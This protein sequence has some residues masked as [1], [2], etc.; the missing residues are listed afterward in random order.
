[1]VLTRGEF[2]RAAS[3]LVERLAACRK[4]NHKNDASSCLLD[5]HVAPETEIQGSSLMYLIHPPFTRKMRLDEGFMQGNHVAEADDVD[6]EDE[7]LVIDPDVIPHPTLSSLSALPL[8][9][10]W[11]CSIVYSD[12]WQVPI[13]FFTAQHMDGSP[14]SR[15]A[16]LKAVGCHDGIDSYDFISYDE[17]PVTRVPSFFLHP[18]QTSAR[19]KL[20]GS[21]TDCFLVSWLSMVLPAIGFRMPPFVVP[22]TVATA[23]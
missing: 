11:R 2:N 23:T 14:C 21:T 1:M 6:L 18:C 12:T 7:T 22:Q 15:H 13:L 3:T 10:E 20:M 9:L 8:L 5:W 19:I 16:L 4:N 17:H